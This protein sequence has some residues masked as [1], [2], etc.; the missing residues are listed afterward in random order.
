MKGDEVR[1]L[2]VSN[3]SAGR[4]AGRRVA[5]RATL[6]LAEHGV[7]HRTAE[8]GS[9][10]AMVELLQ[11]EAAAANS[12]GPDP[13]LRVLLIGGDGT[14]HHAA[15]ALAGTD[16]ILGIIPG[17]SGNDIA[18]GLGLPSSLRAA[19]ARALEPA[20]TI[21]LLQIGDRVGVSVATA[22]FSVDVNRRADRLASTLERVGLRGARYSVATVLE[23]PG[24]AQLDL[25]LV[26][27]GVP[28]E[29]SANLIAIGNTSAFGGGMHVA[30]DADP[31]DGLADVVVIGPA[32]SA[33][34]G[35]LLPRVFGGSHVNVPEVSVTRVQ[36]V[37][38]TRAD[39]PDPVEL[40]ADGEFLTELPATISILPGALHVAGARGSATLAP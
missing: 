39:G 16:V 22:G 13:A 12:R 20:S 15:N 34:F 25:T 29:E 33:R 5:E 14:I 27:D 7:A 17:G 10:E 2:L 1:T 24:L 37:H 40:W 32:S 18:R 19:V 4:G 9:P 35:A 11:T 6:L 26:L 31:H 21:D 36:E 23:L 38:L 8:P 3:A 30:P 28:R